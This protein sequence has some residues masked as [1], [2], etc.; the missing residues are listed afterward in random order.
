PDTWS[1]LARGTISQNIHR[2]IRAIADH[3]RS[4]ERV[5]RRLHGL[6]RHFNSRRD[7]DA[8]CHSSIPNRRIRRNGPGPKTNRT[9]SLEKETLKRSGPV[10]FRSR[11]IA[12]NTTI[13]DATMTEGI[14]V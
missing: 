6:L 13:R 8:F 2:H 9:A 14:R 4:P 3:N 10:S 12:P 1:A 5:G 11:P 7:P